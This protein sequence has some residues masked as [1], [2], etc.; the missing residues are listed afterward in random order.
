MSEFASSAA[1][2]LFDRIGGRQ[3]VVGIIGMGY[4]GLP[5]AVAAFDAGFAI[6]GFDVDPAKISGICGRLLCC[7]SYEQ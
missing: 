7:L 6:T 4:V 1:A 2:Q 5:L 3:S